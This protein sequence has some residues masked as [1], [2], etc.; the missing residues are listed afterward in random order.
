MP[1][2]PGAPAPCVLVPVGQIT[3]P[4]RVNASITW[5][6]FGVLFGFS[7][8]RPASACLAALNRCYAVGSSK[9]G[10]VGSIHSAIV[11]GTR[12]M[13]TTPSR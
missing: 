10:N 12:L 13:F 2:C 5:C 8:T 1:T 7:I 4:E 6:S 3:I 9:S 11:A